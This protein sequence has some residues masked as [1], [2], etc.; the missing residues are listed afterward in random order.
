MSS[1]SPQNQASL[2]V[3]ENIVHNVKTITF[4]RSSMSAITGSAAGIL[5][6]TGYSGVYFRNGSD[7]WT[8]GVFGGLFSY[9][10][11]WTL[12]YGIVHVYD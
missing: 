10:L 11:F 7:V 3:P 5:G 12:L 9:V 6:L 4:I 8:E 1:Q 2:Y